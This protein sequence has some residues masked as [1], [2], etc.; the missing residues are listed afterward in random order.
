MFGFIKNFRTGGSKYIKLDKADLKESNED[1]A[2][3]GRGW[4]RIYT[5]KLETLDY[6]E[7]D[8]L[9]Y[10]EN[11]T[12]ALV[13]IDIGAYSSKNIDDSALDFFKYILGKFQEKGKEVIL[14]IVYDTEGKG[15]QKEP[16]LFS[17]VIIHMQQL[18]GIV[19][20]YAGNIFL[21]QGLFVGSWGEM[22]TSKFLSGDRFKIL[23]AKWKQETGG[24]VKISFR[25]PVQVRIVTEKNNSYNDIGIFDDAIFAS[26]TH[27]GTFGIADENRWE[28]PWCKEK[29]LEFARKISEKIP[30]G[31]E[32]VAG[33]SLPS[34]DETIKLLRDMNINYLNCI[35]DAK[36]LEYWKNQSTKEYGNIYSYISMHLGYRITVKDVKLVKSGNALKI[37]FANN[38]FSCIYFETCLALVIEEPGGNKSKMEIP[39]D[40][41]FLMPGNTKEAVIDNIRGIANGSR[42]YLELSRKHDKKII[43]F[44]NA[45]AKEMLFLG[46]LF[47]RE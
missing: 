5:F 43:H 26:P 3:P 20:E 11:E 12:L 28:K 45:G 35:H 15:M 16:S 6:N 17:Q 39:F 1:F 46:S 14:R 36:I 27:L 13:L 21:F 32:A 7:L 42:L 8:W 47:T 2:N 40:S 44:D 29:E 9:Y 37:I 23:Y 41:R 19:K 22:H 25:T 18:G 4:Y 34:P 38:G 24:S 31:G 30:C 33:E 10:N